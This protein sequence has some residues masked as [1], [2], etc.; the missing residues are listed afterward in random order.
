MILTLILIALVGV[1]VLLAGL[2]LAIGRAFD[3]VE[4]AIADLAGDEEVDWD[5]LRAYAIQDA[6][7]VLFTDRPGIQFGNHNTQTN[8]FNEYP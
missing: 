7:D 1:L 4:A 6:E 3:Q 2:I 8:T 5:A